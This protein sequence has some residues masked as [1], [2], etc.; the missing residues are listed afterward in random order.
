MDLPEKVLEKARQ[1]K[2]SEVVPLLSDHL[3]G[4]VRGPRH[5]SVVVHLLWCTACR[6][7][8]KLLRR[9]VILAQSAGLRTPEADASTIRSVLNKLMRDVEE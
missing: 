4:A 6:R 8:M 9:I 2:C 5:R 3:D 1:M 7:E